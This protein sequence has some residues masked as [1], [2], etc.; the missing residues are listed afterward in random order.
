MITSLF[1]LGA[2]AFYGAADFL[3]GGIATRRATTMATVLTTQGAGLLMLL[4]ARR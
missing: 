4:R 2:A 3:G 1:A